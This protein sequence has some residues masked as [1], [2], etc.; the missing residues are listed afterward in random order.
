M[1]YYM[2]ELVGNFF[3][4]IQKNKRVIIKGNLIKI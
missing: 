1:I 3:F 2:K 4:H